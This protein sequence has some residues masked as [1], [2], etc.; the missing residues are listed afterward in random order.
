[1]STHIDDLKTLL[2]HEIRV[3][4]KGFSCYVNETQIKA[5]NCMVLFYVDDDTGYVSY[6][7][8]PYYNTGVQVSCRHK[9]YEDARKMA[10]LALEKI[11]EN[12]KTVSGVYW[13]PS[14]V[15]TYKGRDE[16]S[17]GYWWTF[18]IIMQGGE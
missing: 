2:S 5:T 7:N 15:P 16:F 13:Q 14:G 1:M 8:R 18:N 4:G 6:N 10:F 3:K 12:R 9:Q 11:N 17:D